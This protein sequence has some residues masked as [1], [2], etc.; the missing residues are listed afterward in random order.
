MPVC[1]LKIMI[2]GITRVGPENQMLC[3]DEQC[4]DDNRPC[5]KYGCNSSTVKVQAPATVRFAFR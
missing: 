2:R 3:K 1:E 4:M 5:T